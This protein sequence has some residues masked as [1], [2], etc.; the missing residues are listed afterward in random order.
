MKYGGDELHKYLARMFNDVFEKRQPITGTGHSILI[1]L[2]KP[3]KPKTSNNTRPIQLVN[4]IRKILSNIALNRLSRFVEEYVRVEQSGF[5]HGR[6]TADVLC[7]HID[8]WQE[9]S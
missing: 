7:G 3:N 2:N 9:Q 4:S 1:A 6:S 5:R 8:G